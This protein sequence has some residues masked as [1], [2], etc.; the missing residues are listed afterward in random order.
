VAEERAAAI[1]AAAAA[2]AA[3]EVRLALVYCAAARGGEDVGGG[4][5]GGGAEAAAE[6]GACEEE[7]VGGAE[8][9]ALGGGAGVGVSNNK[10]GTLDS[11]VDSPR[12]NEVHKTEQ[13]R[14]TV[15]VSWRMSECKAEVAALEATLEAQGVNTI[16]VCE[17]AGGDLLKAVTHSMDSA[18]L[19]VIMGTE[20]YGKPTS[21]LIDTYQEM[22]RI[23]KE[24]PFFLINMNPPSSLFTF[25]ESATN[26]VL[27]LNVIAWERWEIGTPIPNRL[28]ANIM[29]KL[30]EVCSNGGSGVG[31]VVEEEVKEEEE[32]EGTAQ[33]YRDAAGAAS[34][35]DSGSG[36]GIG[37]AG[38]QQGRREE[39][40]VST[41]TSVGGETA[42]QRKLEAKEG[43]DNVLAVMC[44]HQAN[45]GEVP[46]VSRLQEEANAVR[47]VTDHVLWGPSTDEM[48]R[49]ISKYDPQVVHLAGHNQYK[50]GALRL[51]GFGE[52]GGVP[53]EVDPSILSGMIVGSAVDASAA[54]GQ[55]CSLA[56]V[57]ISACDSEKFAEALLQEA[58]KE[59]I[60]NLFVVCW[61][62]RTD[63]FYCAR[64]AKGF[65]DIYSHRAD[66]GANAWVRSCY[67]SGRRWCRMTREIEL[68]CVRGS[69]ATAIETETSEFEP[70]KLFGAGEANQGSGESTETSPSQY[71][72]LVRARGGS[73]TFDQVMELFR[74]FCTKN[75][76]IAKADVEAT[77]EQRLPK[78]QASVNSGLFGV[79]SKAFSLGESAVQVEAIET[80]SWQ[81][82]FHGSLA[83]LTHPE[84]EENMT[85][86]VD[87]LQKLCG[88]N[89]YLSKLEEGSIIAHITSPQSDFERVRVVLKEYTGRKQKLYCGVQELKDVTLG[90]WAVVDTEMLLRLAKGRETELQKMFAEKNLEIVLSAILLQPLQKEVPARVKNLGAKAQAKKHTFMRRTSFTELFSRLKKHTVL[91]Q[92]KT[93][94]H[95]KGNAPIQRAAQILSRYRRGRGAAGAGAAAGGGAGEGAAEAAAAAAAAAAGAAAAAA[96]LPVLDQS[97]GRI[98]WYHVETRE[99]TWADPYRPLQPKAIHEAG[100]ATLPSRAHSAPSRITFLLRLVKDDRS[101]RNI[102]GPRSATQPHT[103]PLPISRDDWCIEYAYRRKAIVADFDHRPRSN[104]TGSNLSPPNIDLDNGILSFVCIAM[105]TQLEGGGQQDCA[106]RGQKRLIQKFEEDCAQR[107]QKRLIQKFEE[108]PRIL[109]N[110]AGSMPTLETL[111]TFMRN[112]FPPA[113]IKDE[114]VVMALI[115]FERLLEKARLVLSPTTWRS[116]VLSSMLM[117]FN[118]WHGDPS[119]VAVRMPKTWKVYESFTLKRVNELMLAMFELQ[120]LAACE[121]AIYDAQG[122]ELSNMRISS[123]NFTKY[124]SQLQ[125]LCASVGFL[126]STDADSINAIQVQ[127]ASENFSH[128]GEECRRRCI[129][130][131]DVDQFPFVKE[132]SDILAGLKRGNQLSLFVVADRAMAQRQTSAD[133]NGNMASPETNPQISDMHSTTTTF[134]KQINGGAHCKRLPADGYQMEAESRVSVLTAR[135]QALE[136]LEQTEDNRIANLECEVDEASPLSTNDISHTFLLQFVD[137]DLNYHNTM[138]SVTVPARENWVGSIVRQI[139]ATT[140]IAPL[141]QIGLMH[142][143]LEEPMFFSVEALFS[144]SVPVANETIYVVIDVKRTDPSTLVS[145]RHFFTFNQVYRNVLPLAEAH[146]AKKRW[147]DRYPQ[148]NP[149]GSFKYEWSQQMG[150]VFADGSPFE[151]ESQL[152]GTFTTVATNAFDGYS[153]KLDVSADLTSMLSEGDWIRIDGHD[154]C[155][156]HASWRHGACVALKGR[157][158]PGAAGMFSAEKLKRDIEPA[159]GR[160][161]RT[162]DRHVGVKLRQG[163]MSEWDSV[164]FFTF[165][166][167]CS[168]NLLPPPM[169]VA[170]YNAAVAAG[171]PVSETEEQAY[172]IS[173]KRSI[174]NQDIAHSAG[175]AMRETRF[176]EVMEEARACIRALVCDDIVYRD[177]LLVQQN[178]IGVGNVLEE[179]ST[180]AQNFVHFQSVYRNVLPLAEAHAA[181]KRWIDRYPQHN[182][183]GSFKYEWSQQMGTVFAD[184]SPFEVESQLPGTFT[185]CDNVCI[186]PSVIVVATNQQARME[187]ISRQGSLSGSEA[188]VPPK[189]PV[190]LDAGTMYAV[191]VTGNRIQHF[192]GSEL[193]FDVVHTELNVSA[194]LTAMLTAGDWIR[195]NGHDVCVAKVKYSVHEK[196]VKLEGR[197]FPGAAGMFF[198]AEKLKRDIEPAMQRSGRSIDQYVRAKFR[199]GDMSEWDSVAFF[200]FFCG[201]SHNLLPPPMSVAKYKAAVAVGTPVSETE[202]QAYRINQKRVIRHQD[203]TGSTST[204][205]SEDR[206]IEVM[207]EARACIR[208]LVCDDIVYR[209]ELLAQQEGIEEEMKKELQQAKDTT[210]PEN[211]LVL[212]R[213]AHATTMALMDRGKTRSAETGDMAGGGV[214]ERPKAGR[215]LTGR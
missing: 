116:V 37:A 195:I 149:D 199:Q 94:L 211:D 133:G 107:G 175:T 56:C 83:D 204:T 174:R 130:T 15:M 152:P 168:H 34:G 161:G 114:I 31:G 183:D 53:T 192:D 150:T 101:T 136:D 66:A 134:D 205:M 13:G 125:S 196:C 121:G 102:S 203:D 84:M 188:R 140:G 142:Q 18:D 214:V 41:T 3:G 106:Q 178:V 109:P 129:S 60:K 108:N 98:Y 33:L 9:G 57:I 73:D 210:G 72:R 132:G 182:L 85:V 38:F 172:R 1:Y 21:G 29:K 87:E 25:K 48:Q 61:P 141:Y 170:K 54:K 93:V 27:N 100:A 164:A 80:I 44:S 171:T 197:G 143:G 63:D 155:V 23:K 81:I 165:F 58:A 124:Y 163:D 209:D 20:T 42:G 49:H 117:G 14:M 78:Q 71:V 82:K 11:N 167:G 113:Q 131:K 213:G 181:K 10:R 208:A 55:A 104:S 62:K 35:S 77:T 92:K 153:V 96:W 122:F 166:C 4:G 99:T 76:E 24:K 191:N 39:M 135:I 52:D 207:E 126:N 151:V 110:P 69:V 123:S 206:F 65:Y 67:N 184:G 74:R 16:V 118:V 193:A 176:I 64:F 90:D 26:T 115:Y 32:E 22:L 36:A 119:S 154:V 103:S 51:I 147:I 144:D 88:A 86:F 194:D 19:C 157:G 43:S 138:P 40:G 2:E 70:P 89:A 180:G 185:T 148:Q 200:T 45:C 97:S 187:P 198:T 173:Q 139:E 68:G 75:R 177:E 47:Q 215:S 59:G 17:S 162:L 189:P 186:N 158:F 111:S 8:A 7:V 12:A 120:E 179:I 30:I 91:G 79:L 46:G 28:A 95:T 127:Y 105:H 146:A 5:G 160:N 190:S 6:G 112:I 201:C 145:A 169:S 159:M 137:A 202:E 212:A 128:K 156:A 50:E